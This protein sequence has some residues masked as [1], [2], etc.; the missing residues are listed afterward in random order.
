MT[1][2]F[3]RSSAR[4]APAG[5]VRA[6]DGSLVPLSFYAVQPRSQVVDI[7][8][9]DPPAPAVRALLGDG[10]PRFSRDFGWQFVS[11]PRQRA[12]TEWEGVPGWTLTVPIVFDKFREDGSVEDDIARLIRMASNRVGDRIEP[13]VVQVI[14]SAIPPFPKLLYVIQGMEETESLVRVDGLRS[15]AAYTMTF[16]EYT[17]MDVLTTTKPTPAAAAKAARP[18]SPATGART[19]TVVRGDTLSGIAARHG[20]KRWQDIANLNRI[21]DPRTIKPGQVL[22]LP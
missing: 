10:R 3:R 9:L 16:L 15:R 7:R 4:R 20:I 5:Y 2:P 13:P 11:R 6:E 17:A 19:Y 12:G 22:R 1:R 8:P 18:K 21:R 14:S